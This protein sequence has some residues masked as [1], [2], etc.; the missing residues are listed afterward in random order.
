MTATAAEGRTTA[1][2]CPLYTLLTQILLT[3]FLQQVKE[4]LDKSANKM[5]PHDPI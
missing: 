1:L 3:P 4:S 5:S 2:H